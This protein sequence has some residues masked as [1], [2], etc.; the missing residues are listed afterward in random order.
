MKCFIAMALIL[1]CSA[2]PARALGIGII[3]GDPTGISLSFRTTDRQAFTGAVAWS[4]RGNTSLHL[5]GDYIFLR[6]LSADVKGDLQKGLKAVRP[7]FHYGI[8]ARFKDEIE[9]KISV[10][11]PL[12]LTGRF[13]RAPFDIFI[14][15]VPLLDLT[16]ATEIDLNAAIGARFNF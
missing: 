15:I 3:V 11:F 1:C 14:E 7:F 13:N 8:G 16:P 2:A 5:H 12:G 6:D 9:N 4:F 10:R